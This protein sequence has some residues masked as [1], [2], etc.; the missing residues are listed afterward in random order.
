M[1]DPVFEVGDWIV[2]RTYGIGQVRSIESKS[3]SGEELP[4]YRVRT[5]NG[6]YWASTESDDNPR[7]RPVTGQEQVKQALKE[8]Q[9]PPGELDLHHRAWRERIKSVSSE[10]RLLAMARVIRDLTAKSNLKKLN[11]F[12]SQSLRQ[13]SERFMREWSVSMELD[14]PTVRQRF[15]HMLDAV[16]VVES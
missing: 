6:T 16:D 5:Q 2:H 14:L 4:F 10:G 15:H 3:I 13:L 12:E 7:I 11:D 8:F 1:T 9:Q